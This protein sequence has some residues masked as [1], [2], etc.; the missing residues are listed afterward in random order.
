MIAKREKAVE[1]IVSVGTDEQNEDSHMNQKQATWW[2]AR[3]LSCGRRGGKVDRS[4]TRNTSTC[5]PECI[6]SL[7]LG[8]SANK[9]NS[10]LQNVSSQAL[11][12]CFADI[13]FVPHDNYERYLSS[14]PEN[15][16]DIQR[17]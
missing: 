5:F 3:L 8:S 13:N 15:V 12:L 17:W 14:S 16:T 6:L 11:Y 7:Y 10:Y 9:G 1:S 4:Y 2:E